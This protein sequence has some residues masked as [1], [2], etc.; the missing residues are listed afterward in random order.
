MKHSSSECRFILSP[1][2]SSD[3]NGKEYVAV[4]SHDSDD[5]RINWLIDASASG[6]L[7]GQYCSGLREQ[8]EKSKDSPAIE[9]F[10]M[11]DSY[12]WKIKDK[13]C[14]ISDIYIPDHSFSLSISDWEYFIDMFAE[15][16]NKKSVELKINFLE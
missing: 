5:I 1:L 2:V 12:E 13:I 14:R 16:K 6:G 11:N 7:W 3:E 8:F 10:G 4:I 9:T 15:V